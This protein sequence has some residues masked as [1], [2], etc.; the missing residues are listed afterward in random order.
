[1]SKEFRAD[2][3][4]IDLLVAWFN[5]ASSWPLYVN[6]QKLR[7]RASV[8]RDSKFPDIE[9]VRIERHRPILGAQYTRGMPMDA[10]TTY[11][12]RFAVKNDGQVDQLE[13][14]VGESEVDVASLAESATNFENLSLSINRISS[15]R[16]RIS[17][18]VLNQRAEVATIEE[19]LSFGSEIAEQ[20]SDYM[21]YRLSMEG[22]E[23]F[24]DGQLIEL[25]KSLELAIMA[26][27]EELIR[28]LWQERDADDDD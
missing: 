10:Y 8:V 27:L 20:I 3:Q 1:M 17:E 15:G 4:A 24:S 21:Y 6:E 9:I 18:S 7:N 2:S 25:S 14:E 23:L 22:T 5:E 26:R 11:Y 16:Y 28:D 12:M 13:D 19:A